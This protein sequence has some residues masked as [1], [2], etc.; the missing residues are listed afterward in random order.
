M[1]KLFA[2][3]FRDILDHLQLVGLSVFQAMN[4][5]KMRLVTTRNV[6]IL[7][8][9][10]A[11]LTPNAKSEITIPFVPVLHAT[12]AIRSLDAKLKLF[13]SLHQPILASLRPA[14]Q[15]LFAVLLAIKHLVLACLK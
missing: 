12:L 11:E 15:T 10:L 14:V 6:L 4:A 5:H 13:K 1:A 7:V 2:L 8:L 3:V 9:E